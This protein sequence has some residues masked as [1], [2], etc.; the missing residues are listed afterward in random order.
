MSSCTVFNA[1]ITDQVVQL[2]NLPRIASGSKEALQIRCNFCGKWE[3]CGKAAVFY[4]DE[5]EVYHVPI[6]DGLVTVP[7]EVLVDE[8]HFWLGFVGQDDLTRTTE[9]IRVEVVKGALTVATA[10]P[11]DP[12][13][14]IYQQI[15]A[16]YASTEANVETLCNNLEARFEAAIAVPGSFDEASVFEGTSSDGLVQV[17]IRSNGYVASARFEVTGMDEKISPEEPSYVTDFFIPPAYAP[18]TGAIAQNYSYFG[19]MRLEIT[20]PDLVPSANGWSRVAILGSPDSMPSYFYCDA[21]YGLAIP[22]LPELTDI[23]KGLYKTYDTAGDAVRAQVDDHDGR[24]IGLGENCMNLAYTVGSMEE[25]VGNVVDQVNAMDEDVADHGRRITDLEKG[26]GTGGGDVSAV[27]FTEQELTPEQQAQ[28]RKNI[29]AGLPPLRFTVEKVGKNYESSKTFQE[30]YEAYTE[31]RTLTCQYGGIELPLVSALT[32]DSLTF[33]VMTASLFE[34]RITINYDEELN[35]R[36]SVFE[37]KTPSINIGDQTWGGDDEEWEV[38]FTDT[39]NGMVD[40]KV[41]KLR[42]VNARDYGAKGDGVTDDTDAIQAALHYAEETS[43]PL[44]IPAGNYLVSK[45][46]STYTRDSEKAKQSKA[47]HIFGSGMNTTFTTTAEFE[48]EYVFYIDVY[49]TNWRSLQVRDFALTIHADTSGIYFRE[50]GMKSVVENL[51][52][53]NKCKENASVRAGIYC[54]SATVA[55]FQRIKVWGNG[56]DSGMVVRGHSVRFV[57]CDVT[58]C[59]WGI[60]LSGGSNWTIDNCRI[61]ENEYGV[62]QNSSNNILQ[63]DRGYDFDGSFVNLTIKGNRFEHNHKR[64][65]VLIAYGGGYLENSNITISNNYFTG[66]GTEVDGEETINRWAMQF[67]RCNGVTIEYNYFKGDPDGDR[68]Q[69]IQYIASVSNVVLRG[70][71]AAK[72][73]KDGVEVKSTSAL[74]EEM[75][76]YYGFVNDIEATQSTD[77]AT[78]GVCGNRLQAIKTGGTIDVTYSNV[79]SVNDGVEVTGLKTSFG[80]VYYTQEVTLVA[81]GSVTVKNTSTLKLNGGVDF[82]MGMCDTLT[83]VKLWVDSGTRW[84]EKSRSVNRAT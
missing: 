67:A 32:D 39:I 26:G 35:N 7:W 12:T 74:C 33:S 82:A 30:L 57:D 34:I 23:R 65:I 31:G 24:L 60:Y 47:L 51:W 79:F 64:A 4:R 58:Y 50:I 36:A 59:K 10:T 53:I 66:L 16:A 37:G 13:P 83:L 1:H 80:D 43:L 46:I 76:S 2:S 77:R 45:T 42:I 78:I 75:C 17:T 48:G 5:A 9:A 61:D 54:D 69:N 25:T 63:D 81:N 84:V 71:I 11:Q 21:T 73:Y 44:Y 41:G 6:V 14:D 3:G 8:G 52:V 27:R 29:G 70:N 72:W 18:M 55:T 15:L 49:P 38:D 56:K 20:S 19:D 22:S 40:D 68:R 28:A 62:Y